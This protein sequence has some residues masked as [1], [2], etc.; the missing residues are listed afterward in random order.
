MQTSG[1]MK[2]NTHVSQA[3]NRYKTLQI[4]VKVEHVD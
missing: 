1:D 3:D 4:S 2:I